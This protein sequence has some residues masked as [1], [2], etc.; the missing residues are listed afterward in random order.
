MKSPGKYTIHDM[1]YK[2]V[3]IIVLLI[4]GMGFTIWGSVVYM[5]YPGMRAMR[6]AAWHTAD[7]QY[8]IGLTVFGVVYALTYFNNKNK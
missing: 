5:S 6:R 4:I 7:V 8:I 3:I 2:N 1:K